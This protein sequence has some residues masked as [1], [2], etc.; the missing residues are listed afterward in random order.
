MVKI[1]RKKKNVLLKTFKLNLDEHPKTKLDNF[2]LKNRNQQK[3]CDDGCQY[4]HKKD[5]MLPHVLLETMTEKFC[6][7]L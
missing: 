1:V 4:E 2:R 7:W 3:F 6:G 5:G